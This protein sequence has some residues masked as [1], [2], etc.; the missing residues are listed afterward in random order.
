MVKFHCWGRYYLFGDENS[1]E[2]SKPELNQFFKN[3][4]IIDMCS[5][6]GHTLV[7]TANGDVYVWG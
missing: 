4:N 2:V 7:L 6:K 5:G 1:E 3:E